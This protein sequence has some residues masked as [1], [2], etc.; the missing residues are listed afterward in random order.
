[1]KALRNGSLLLALFVCSSVFAQSN[2]LTRAEVAEIKAK[3]VAVQQALGADPDGYLKESEDFYLPTEITSATAASRFWPVSSSVSLRYTDRALE[4][5]E[6]NA[7]QAAEAFQQK[8]LA[9]IASNDFDAIARLS[10]ESLQLSQLAV[11]GASIEPKEDMSVVIEFNA[12]PSASIDP[13]AVVFE[14]PG[15][16][17]L[18]DLSRRDRVTLYL[19]PVGLAETETLSSF[20]L[21][22]ADDG[23]AKRTGVYNITITLHGNGDDIE[24]WV[25]QFD[26]AAMLRVID[27][28]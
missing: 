9:A 23:I 2:P 27:S 11:A 1:M 16:I 6:A 13:D 26:R 7:E 12:S 19:D 14:S 17:A 24:N 28:Q 15:A 3:L 10:E 21:K 20:R 18:R 8:Y 4:E 25:Q 5:S 22:T